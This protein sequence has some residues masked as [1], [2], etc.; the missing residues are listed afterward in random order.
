[1][2]T[3]TETSFFKDVEEYRKAVN[4]S[5]SLGL[6]ISNDGRITSVAW[7]SPAFKA[8]LTEGYV[9]LAVDGRGYKPEVLKAAISAAKGG[10]DPIE[11]LLKKDDRFRTVRIDYHDGL[12]YPHLARIEGTPDRLDRIFT[13]L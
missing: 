12:K 5:Y 1:V 6:G 10:R 4:L 9:L 3:E 8:G 11:L 2:Y 13:P 7:Q